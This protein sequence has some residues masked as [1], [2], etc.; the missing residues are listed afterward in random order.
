MVNQELVDYLKR[1][2][3]KG[4]AIQDLRETLLQAGY[5]ESDVDEA[6]NNLH[7]GK[8]IQTSSS[9]VPRNQPTGKTPKWI[10][11]FAV[12]LLI[13]G[14][15]NIYQ[16]VNLIRGGGIIADIFSI[17]SFIMPGMGTAGSIF[18]G[19]FTL[20]GVLVIL[21]GILQLILAYG[22]WK[23]RN[24]ARILTIITIAIPLMLTIIGIP[25]GILVIWIC[26]RKKTKEAFGVN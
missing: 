2:L 7:E 24:W 25:F 26:M 10:V 16:G 9:F 8:E 6:I 12:I 1:N 19:I 22:W 14:I 20:F 13:D 17:F 5:S 4:F 23:L 3:E 18:G 21:L 11:I 15:I